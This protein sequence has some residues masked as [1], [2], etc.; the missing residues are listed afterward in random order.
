MTTQTEYTT[1]VAFNGTTDVTLL[2][3]P[4]SGNRR[5]VASVTVV[6][7]DTGNV[8]PIL[9]LDEN[10]TQ[11]Q[12]SGSGDAYLV[13]ETFRGGAGIVLDAT[14]DTL[15]GKMAAAITSANCRALVRWMEVTP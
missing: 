14:T 1:S 3:A 12:D 2:A 5:I 4:S 15:K 10:G 9:M 6:N 11:T 13:G 7:I 8:S